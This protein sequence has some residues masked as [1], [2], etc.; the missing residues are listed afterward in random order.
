MLKSSLFATAA[1]LLAA[2]PALAEDYVLTLKDHQFS[3]KELTVPAGQK[4]KLTV[5]NDDATPAEFESS[6]LHR[7]KVVGANSSITVNLGPLK[8]GSYKFVDDFHEDTTTGTLI[9]K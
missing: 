6:D 7:E 9:A 2:T 1:L 4:I 5:K 3:P 8:A